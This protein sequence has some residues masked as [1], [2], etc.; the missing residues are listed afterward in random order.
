MKERAHTERVIRIATQ[1]ERQIE[2]NVRV[3][4]L[5]ESDNKRDGCWVIKMSKSSNRRAKRVRVGFAEYQFR[6]RF[7]GFVWKRIDLL[8]RNGS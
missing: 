2:T 4:M 3:W 6:Q 5:M 8:C 7:V 1:R